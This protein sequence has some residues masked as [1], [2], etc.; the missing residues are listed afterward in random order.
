M[1]HNIPLSFQHNLER[2]WGRRCPSEANRWVGINTGCYQNPDH[3]RVVDA[4]RT[5]IDS[6]R[7]PGLWRELVTIQTTELPLLPLFYL[8]NVQLY[9]EGVTGIKGDTAMTPLTWNIAEW[10]IRR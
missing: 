1:V 3:D 7:I 2:L 5:E 8:I 10:D 6:A 9:R 4:L